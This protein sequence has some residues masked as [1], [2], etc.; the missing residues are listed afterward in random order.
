MSKTFSKDNIPLEIE[1]KFLIAYPSIA[2]L[3][4]QK[5]YNVAEITQTYLQSNKKDCNMRIRKRTNSGITTYTL[6]YKKDITSLVR[7]EYEEEISK[8]KY[9]ELLSLKKSGFT[10][11]QKQRHCF[12]YNKKL[13]ELDIFPF[14][15]DRAF[16]E[17]ELDSVDEKALLPSFITII[18]EVT[19]NPKYRNYSLA[20]N[21]FTEVI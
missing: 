18:K 20:Q 14:W 16:L 9:L 13:F 4:K 1:R 3:E 6:T 21:I 10:S 5:G 2:L 12:F 19:N 7:E 8:E 15:Q 17:I 11:I